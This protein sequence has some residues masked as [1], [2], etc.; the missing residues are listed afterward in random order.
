MNCKNCNTKLNNTY[1]FCH[2]CG[3]KVITKRL[4]VSNILQNA[5]AQFFNYDNKVFKTFWFLI[6]KPETVI[7]DYINGVRKRY[8][9]V[10]QY[11]AISLT[12]TGLQF[13]ILNTFFENPFIIDSSNIASSPN[14]AN[15]NTVEESFDFVSDVLSK[16]YTLF[17]I[18]SLP[19]STLLSWLTYKLKNKAY[20]FS[21]HFIINTYYSA[22]MLILLA[23]GSVIA[24][25]LGM[26][27]MTF[28]LLTTPFYFLY[29][30]FVLKRIYQLPVLESIAYIF[31]YGVGYFIFY[32][33]LITITALTTT[34][35]V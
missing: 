29:F 5:S 21:E 11:F 2:E 10:I 22:Q 4:T 12:I 6:T 23:L 18:F 35:L 28:N 15:P 13:F 19:V 16:Y 1:K 30:W 34:L 20:N 17:Y 26:S 32:L 33:A 9:N 8:I 7:L 25:S 24:V 31:I 27:Y 3:A 14:I